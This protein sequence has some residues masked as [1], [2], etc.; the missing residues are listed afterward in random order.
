[1][2]QKYLKG[3]LIILLA[4]LLGCPLRIHAQ[5]GKC[6][7][8]GKVMDESQLPVAYASVALYNGK[9]PITGVITDDEGRF[10]LKTSQ[11]DK[12][13][14][15]AIEFI[16]YGKFEK[17]VTPNTSRIQLGTIIL[18]ENAISLGEVVVS[19]KEVAQ[20]PTIEHTTLHASA[21][22]ASGKGTAIDILRSSSSVSV[23]NDVISVRGNSNILVLM[24]GVPTTATDLS[25]IPAANIK[26][27]EVITH[28]DASHD[29]GGTGGIIHIISRKPKAEGM[30]GVVSANYGFNHFVTGNVAFSMNKP[31]AS[32]KF[33]YNT[34]YEDDVITST[35]NRTIKSSGYEVAQEMEAKRYTYN[36]NL[37]MGADFRMGAK[38]RLSVD[39]KFILPRLN[40]EQD[41]HNRFTDKGEVREEYRHNDVTWN[42]ENVEA[43]VAYTHI[44]QPEVSDFSIKGSVSK[45]WGHRPSY[46]RMN[47]EPVNRSVSGGSPFIPTLQAD[48]KRKFKTGTLT[49]GVK[50][51]YRR[52]DIYHRFY[53][54]ADDEWI[55]SES[56]S[57]DLLHTE[58][59]PA[60]Y[61][62][63]ASRIGKKFTYKAG[64]RGEFSTVTLR[65]RHEAIDGRENG[66][67]LAPSL[68]GTYVVSDNQELSM[69]VS[70][71]IGRPSYPQ[72][73]PYM[74]MVDATTYEQGNMNL[75]AEKATLLDVSYQLRW[76]NVS[77]FANAYV[78]H[79]EGY[80]S[81]ITKM[82]DGKLITT[83]VNADKD[84]KAGLDLSLGVTPV[85]WMSLSLGANTYHV[86]TKGKYEGEDI[87]NNGWT[88]NSTFMLDILPWKGG[89]AQIQYFVTTPEYFPQLTSEL[90]HRMNIGFQQQLMKGAL[91]VSMLFTDVL[92]TDAWEVSSDN[93]LFRLKNYSNNKGHMLWLGVSYNF[94][95][96]KGKSAQKTEMDRSLIKLGM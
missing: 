88:N 34:K 15:L 6:D 43:S 58:L 11:T 4:M 42:R 60:A 2:K 19:A 32:W 70:R 1:M 84:M 54:L 69:A 57:N 3:Q 76:K 35:L 39:V 23:S 68:S 7:I 78:N 46:Y 82:D 77:L 93:N 47:G 59:V 12:E 90:T 37:G 91:T 18:K 26:S 53:A 92:D 51:T 10:T 27:I 96:F 22:L 28:P 50:L 55:Y 31:K 40:V 63:F 71:R 38:D 14:R 87:A 94:N 72:L 74:S 62:M 85:Q 13:Y 44:I 61:A 81:Q 73:N 29:A 8:A 95:K 30:S 56:M 17:W 67:F 79:T 86:S 5:A 21:N 45:I 16:G 66:F 20:K 80:I 24:D 36:N 25:T 64:I 33:N 65:S 83:Y 9:T 52:N 75:Q 48:Y 41:L 89:N 49:S